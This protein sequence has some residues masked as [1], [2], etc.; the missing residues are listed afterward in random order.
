MLKLLDIHQSVFLVLYW[1]KRIPDA[2]STEL[3]QILTDEGHPLRIQYFL[4]RWFLENAIKADE[5]PALKAK[6]QIRDK[7]THEYGKYS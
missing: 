5:L 7:K 3:A 6:T 2:F 1:Q 4:I